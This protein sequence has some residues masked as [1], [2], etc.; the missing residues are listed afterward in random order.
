MLQQPACGL[1]GRAAPL[2]G[3]GA[4][5]VALAVEFGQHVGWPAWLFQAFSPFAH[6]MPFSGVPG[7]VPLIALTVLAAALCA[8]GLTALSRRDLGA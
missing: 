6:V 3:Y 5:A 2:I 8:L 4:L 7:A 1:T